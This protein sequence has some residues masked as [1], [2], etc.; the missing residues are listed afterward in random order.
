MTSPSVAVAI[1]EDKL[2]IVKARLLTSAS[3]PLEKLNEP[4]HRR[5]V[6][7]VL[8]RHFATEVPAIFRP[9]TPRLGQEYDEAA[10]AGRL[11]QALEW[12]ITGTENP[13][14]LLTRLR[15]ICPQPELCAKVFKGG[16]PVY[17]CRD[18]GIDGTCVLCVECFNNSEHKNH[19]YRIASSNSG[20]CDCGDTGKGKL[21]VWLLLI[22]GLNVD[23]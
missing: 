17:N 15:E 8:L 2:E 18:C 7:N 4:I 10:C 23:F 9:N 12:Y 21:L 11:I 19:R 13:A 3:Q 5:G 1:E 22:L 20:Y 16:E 6:I 14:Q